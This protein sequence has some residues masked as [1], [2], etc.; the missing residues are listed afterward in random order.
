MKKNTS[1]HSA[2]FKLR[3]VASLLLALGGIALGFAAFS[4]AT[5]QSPKGT[6]EKDSP[7]GVQFRG[8]APIVQ[9]D[10]S[11]PLRDIT[12]I[13]ATGK[14]RENEERDVV[15]R[16]A[17]FIHETDP[18]VQATATIG[19]APTIA[20][21]QVSFDAQSG[22]ASPPDPV[23]AVGPNHVITMA[24]STF[25][26]LTK[27]GTSVFGPAA[28]NTLFAGF[29]GACQTENAGDPVVV[30]DQLAD[31]WIM[32]QFTA[33]GPTYFN[34]V[35]V[36]TSSDPAGSYTRYAISTGSNFPDYPKMSLWPDAYYISTRE[37]SGNSFAGVGAFALNRQQAIAGNPAA[38]VISF[39]VP[40]GAQPFNV[41]DGLLPADL[42]GST[43]PPAGSPHYFVGTMDNNGPY[44]APQDA[45]TLWKFT[46]NF[47]NPQ[48]SSFVLTNTIPVAPFNSVLGLCGG[49]RACIPQQGSTL[50]L[51]HLGYRQRPTFRLAYRN[52]GTHESLV[53]SQSVS[54][55][56]GSAGEVSG[57]RWYELRS[58][59][60]S[61][62]I[63]QQGTFA[64]GVTDGIHRWMGSIAMDANGN[65][66]MGYSTSSPTMFASIWYTGRNVGSPLGTMPLGEAAIFN[67]IAPAGPLGSRWGDYT[68]IDIDPVDDTTFWYVNEYYPAGGT[69][70]R[71]RVGSF[72]LIPAAFP[73]AATATLTSESCSPANSVPDPGETVTMSLCVTNN[74][75]L[76]TANTVGTLQATSGITN[77]SGPQSY[78]AIAPGA[79]AC[80][81][82]TFTASGACGGSIRPNLQLQDGS[83]NFG[84]VSYNSFPLGTLSTSFNQNFDGV[85]APALPSGWTADQGTNAGGS[86]LWT[87]SSTG[88][89]SPPASS[90]PNSAFTPTPG[91]VLD[92][93]L[94][95]PVFSYSTGSRL[96]FRHNFDIEQ[97]S[98]TA[99]YD[100]GVLE[101]SVNGGAWTDI[102]TA[103]GTFVTG[104][105]PIKRSTPGLRTRCCRRARAG[106]E[107]RAAS[108][109]PP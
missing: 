1:T 80:R 37:F 84:T 13:L 49:T 41:G 74:G 55:G 86:P 46:A 22:S 9:S 82:F 29:G 104:A 95:S 7:A 15:H 106:A 98:A 52:Y 109:L 61:P 25:Q 85:T 69:T 54:G 42:D 96:T 88:T 97:Q 30:H 67:G 26:I 89:P 94:I 28:I 38:Q 62:F 47:A 14:R 31:R 18:V 23:M 66:G 40:P 32:M 101:M 27:N 99:A 12:P 59:N 17:G 2:F 39:L 68:A 34:C 45:L 50:R 102:V 16:S 63:H 51:D 108:S 79:T 90:A 60:S 70:W 21:P 107:T 20:P 78:G 35:A 33:A 36:S 4:R 57:M 76:A 91:T 64:P 19:D 81:S 48:A 73:T 87:T 72:K 92:N 75:D 11:P 24:N 8:I 65:M 105:T 103:G 93:R 77:P 10:V 6:P 58:P 5:A 3:V 43:L 71:L 100:A 53:T 56:S 83:T 44:Q